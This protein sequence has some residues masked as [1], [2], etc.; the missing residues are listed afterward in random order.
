MARFS[1]WGGAALVTGASGGI[2]REVARLLAVRG[3]DLVLAA[4]SADALR[5][6]AAELSAA[7]GIRALPWA[8]DLAAEDAASA[9]PAAFRAFD[10]TIDLLVNNAGFG[11][12]GAFGNQGLAREA[13][14]IRLNTVAPTILAAMVLPGMV[15]RGHGRILNVASTAAFAPVPWLATY[16]AT[17]SHLLAWTHALDVE[18]RGSG[19]RV[20]VACP[21]TVST[22]FLETSGADQR[23]TPLPSTTADVVARGI[24]RGLDQGRRVFVIGTLNR[25]H[26]ASAAITPPGLAASIAGVVNRPRDPAPRRD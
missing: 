25:L 2:G 18:L 14:M 22:G 15:R 7:H 1:G 5:A 20:S 10:V 6:L 8:V 3:M 4:R 19:V 23:R 12:Y 16:G 9:V 24:L 26:R 21:G 11:V 13:E 17:K